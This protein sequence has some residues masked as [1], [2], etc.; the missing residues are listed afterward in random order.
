MAEKQ[1]VYSS[2]LQVGNQLF[3]CGVPFRLDSYSGCS[4]NCIYCFARTAELT[5]SSSMR[6]KTTGI[7]AADP[8]DFRSQMF[9]ALDKGNKRA[10]VEI[11][12]MRNRVPIHWGG[13][14][15]ITETLSLILLWY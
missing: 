6:R 9:Q 14:S 1:A 15:A 7:L 13:M 11:E 5:N 10:N 8:K 3:F 2:P 4:H 12:W